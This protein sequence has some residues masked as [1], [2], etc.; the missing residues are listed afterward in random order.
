MNTVR[1]DSEER[2]KKIVSSSLHT[3][4]LYIELQR[5]G[6]ERRKC[7]LFLHSFPGRR[8]LVNSRI[9]STVEVRTRGG[10]ESSVNWEG[11]GGGVSRIRFWETRS[12]SFSQL[13][14]I[15][16]LLPLVRDS[17]EVMREE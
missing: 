9:T 6:K 13:F 4:G 3:Y 10:R 2:K 14:S 15:A 17:T 7:P 12:F 8:V 5:R 16:S 1:E 11:G